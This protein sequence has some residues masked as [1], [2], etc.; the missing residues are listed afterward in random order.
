M[1]G[2]ITSWR[3]AIEQDGPGGAANASVQT[4]PTRLASRGLCA[5]MPAS[6]AFSLTR[7]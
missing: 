5:A 3:R 1:Q 2:P 4:S 6:V 7:T